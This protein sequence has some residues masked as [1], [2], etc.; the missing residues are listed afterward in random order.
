MSYPG[1][2]GLATNKYWRAPLV[3]AN[4]EVIYL[5]TSVFWNEATDREKAY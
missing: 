5:S 3:P 4:V 2:E 1:I